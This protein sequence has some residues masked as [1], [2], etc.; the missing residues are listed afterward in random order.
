V[1]LLLLKNVKEI[2]KF[3][4]YLSAFLIVYISYLLLQQLYVPVLSVVANL[5]K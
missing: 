3:V 5:G 4:K 1:G 2:K